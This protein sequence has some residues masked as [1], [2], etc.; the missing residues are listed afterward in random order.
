MLLILSACGLAGTVWLL[1]RQGR[2]WSV[3]SDTA[4]RRGQPRVA[5]RF[6][7]HRDPGIQI[8]HGGGNYYNGEPR[9][10]QARRSRELVLSLW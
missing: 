7:P 9:Q 3:G 1:Y 10:F 8:R 2:G 4:G 5:V 6:G